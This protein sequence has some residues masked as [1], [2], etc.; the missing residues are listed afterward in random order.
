[1]RRHLAMAAAAVALC[2]AAVPAAHARQ[3]T[4]YPSA[5]TEGE[6]LSAK[7]TLGNPRV[8]VGE[9]I[10]FTI[11][12]YGPAIDSVRVPE[13]ASTPT[14]DLLEREPT[15]RNAG[16]GMWWRIRVSTLE[17]GDVKPEPLE[18]AYA[19]NGAD[20]VLRVEF[21]AVKVESVIGE[22]A[23]PA[24]FRDILGEVVLESPF[25][26]VPWA[27]GAAALVAAGAAAAYFLR[28]RRPE[29]VLAADEWAL[30]EFER[31]SKDAPQARGE[32]GAFYDTLTGIVR[33]YTTRRFAIRAGSQTTREFLDAARAEP[34]F[35]DEEALRLRTLL[36]L[37]DLVKF[38]AAE[39]D[40]AQCERHLAEA[41]DFVE[42]TRPRPETDAS[43]GPRAGESA[44]LTAAE[45][46]AKP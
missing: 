4:V 35:P 27:A 34:G 38:A 16:G 45:P 11:D 13:Q 33:G 40:R 30:A 15:Q 20:K 2:V 8:E 18:V 1:M 32:F 28:R 21:P 41:R 10:L 19:W 3:D 22:K 9:E 37:A 25:A 42:R 17:S 43:N 36:Q 44:P 26:W 7:V 24:Q 31:L 29:R 39:P 6:G 46:G 14:F 5:T 12:L 23:D